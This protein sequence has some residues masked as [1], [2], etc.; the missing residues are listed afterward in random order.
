MSRMEK[1]S[2]SFPLQSETPCPEHR[3][4][5]SGA[6]PHPTLFQFIHF[7]EPILY[8]PFNNAHKGKDVVG[9]RLE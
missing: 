1:K 7:V 9:R 6:A 2:L 3:F 4:S 8:L 5:D